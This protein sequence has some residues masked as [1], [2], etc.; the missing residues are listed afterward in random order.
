M[1]NHVMPPTID[2][3]VIPQLWSNNGI[4]EHRASIMGTQEQSQSGLIWNPNLK[5]STKHVRKPNEQKGLNQVHVSRAIFHTAVA[6][7]PIQ[8]CKKNHSLCF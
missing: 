2:D 8:P 6:G 1:N 5:R 4:G 3:G 7:A